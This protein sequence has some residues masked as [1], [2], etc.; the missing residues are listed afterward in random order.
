MWTT[1]ASHNLAAFLFMGDNVY[2][3]HP[4]YPEVQRYCYYCRQSRKEFRDFAAI[5][6]IYA[7]Y[8]DHDFSGNDSWGGPQAYKP[9]W[10][11]KVWDVFRENWNNP[12]YG[13]GYKSPGCWF[14]FSIADVDFF[15]LDCRYYRDDPNSENPSMLG[16]KQKTWLFNQLKNSKA[17][18]KV[19][20][21]SVPWTFEAK[22]GADKIDT[23]FGYKDERE[24]IFSFLDK[25]KIEGVI[26]IS[27]DRHRSDIWK[28]ERNNGYNLYEFM[29]SRLTNAQAHLT[30]P[31]SIYSYNEKN[32]FGV[33]NF[34]TTL[35]DLL[36]IFIIYNIDNERVYEFK[37][38]HSE[39]SY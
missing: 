29:N 32:S 12:Y 13:G 23:W 34:D 17:T 1:I 30:M 26:L 33:L 25:E 39:L 24:E 21:S 3:D 20:A 4:F 31:G 2:I 38:K 11:V 22:I 14:N 8:D 28:I 15:M 7:I 10:K 27:A 36:L 5:T 37:I 6:P 18:F 19:I 35:S 9:E 16:E